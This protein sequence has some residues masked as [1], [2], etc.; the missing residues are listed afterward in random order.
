MATTPCN[1]PLSDILFIK[2]LRVDTLI[3]IYDWEK[4]AE[5]PLIFDIELS[6]CLTPSAQSD[7]ID[8]TV[9]YKTVSDDIIEWVK[10]SRFE[11]IE[12]L[13]E[14]LC[15]R[16]FDRN[17]KVSEIALTLNKP[18]AVIAAQAVGLKIRRRRIN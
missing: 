15:Q 5:Q 10:A 12:T 7:A 16:I 14:Q 6:T 3:G 18:Q 1:N 11:L 17:P 4:Q 8:D 9:N 2:G 13:A